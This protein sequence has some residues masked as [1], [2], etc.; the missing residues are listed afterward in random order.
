V[1]DNFADGIRQFTLGVLSHEICRHQ[2]TSEKHQRCK[3]KNPRG[4]SHK[5][6]LIK[7]KKQCWIAWVSKAA[8]GLILFTAL[9]LDGNR[10]SKTDIAIRYR[11]NPKSAW[12]IF[13]HSWWIGFW[14]TI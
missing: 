1:P 4:K 2:K 6:P 11:T 12:Q 5:P 9:V 14:R 13:L 3:K 8:A 10:T 7:E